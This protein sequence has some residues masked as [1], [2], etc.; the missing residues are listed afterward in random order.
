M[1]HIPGKGQFWVLLSVFHHCLKHTGLTP[2]SKAWSSIA[3][4]TMSWYSRLVLAWHSEST[5]KRAQYPLP[6]SSLTSPCSQTSH[7][8]STCKAHPCL[9]SVLRISSTQTFRTEQNSLLTMASRLPAP[10]PLPAS[11]THLCSPGSLY[12]LQFRGVP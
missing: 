11:P 5:S 7:H 10:R 12:S 6:V 8:S 3:L 2:C 9:H 1:T 4:G